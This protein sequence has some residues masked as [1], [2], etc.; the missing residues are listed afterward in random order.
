MNPPFCVRSWDN[1]R[2]L[3]R[4]TD[5]SP[6]HTAWTPYHYYTKYDQARIHAQS[7]ARLITATT[8]RA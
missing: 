5:P 3:N 2:M 6:V 7:V 4:H 1:F 8:N